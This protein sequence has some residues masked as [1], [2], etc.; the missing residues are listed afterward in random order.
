MGLNRIQLLV[1]TEF[2]YLICENLLGRG[3]CGISAVNAVPVESWTNRPS[4][5]QPP[6][7]L[8]LSNPAL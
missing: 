4:A 3:E 7:N 5:N 1:C 8:A 6:K 2:V